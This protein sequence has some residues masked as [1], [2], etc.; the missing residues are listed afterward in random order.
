VSI[1]NKDTPYATTYYHKRQLNIA[2]N[3][4][5]LVPELGDYLRQHALAD[6][7]QALTEYEYIAPYWFV[8]RYQAAVNEGATSALYNSPA[9]FQAKA[10]ILDQDRDVLTRYIDAPAFERGDLFYIQNLAIALQAPALQ[11]EQSQV[12]P[13]ATAASAGSAPGAAI[14]SCLP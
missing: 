2:R 13:A 7:Q 1:F 12:D 9:I 5:M 6:V 8:S 3:F 10:F 14:T 4:M 11:A